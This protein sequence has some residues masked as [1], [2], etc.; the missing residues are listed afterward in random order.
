[1]LLS[2][3]SKYVYMCGTYNLLSDVCIN[4]FKL[5]IFYV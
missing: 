5:A 4:N 1:M 2:L 3:V